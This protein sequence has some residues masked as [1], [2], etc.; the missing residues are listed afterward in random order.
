MLST[1]HQAETIAAALSPAQ[2]CA[3]ILMDD[4]GW[5]RRRAREFSTGTMR[6]LS[7]RGIAVSHAKGAEWQLSSLGM[8]VQDALRSRAIDIVGRR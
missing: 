8:A 4:R 6:V 1:I 3:V 7:A 2:Q 5:V